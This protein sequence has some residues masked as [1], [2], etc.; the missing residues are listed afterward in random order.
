[1]GVL[2]QQL[3]KTLKNTDVLKIT[4]PLLSHSVQQE[5]RWSFCFGNL[6]DLHFTSVLPHPPLR[7]WGGGC[8]CVCVWPLETSKMTL[9][10]TSLKLVILGFYYEIEVKMQQS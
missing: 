1:M 2:Y 6:T 7:D 8:V 3:L 10:Q 9:C 4:D 5:I